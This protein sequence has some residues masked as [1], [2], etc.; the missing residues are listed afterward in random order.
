MLD[1]DSL[2]IF[3]TAAET[4]NFTRTAQRLH[5]S[6]PSVSQH[7]QSLEQH[8]GI[9][10]FE[11]H[12]RRVD[13]SAVGAS[14]LPLVQEMLRAGR[15]VEEAARVL[16]GEVSGLLTLACSTSSGKYIV[17]RLLA[18]YRDLYPQ[19]QTAMRV[20]PRS[21]MLDWLLAGEADVGITSQ[22][23]ECTGV[24]Y[25]RFFE[26][27]ISLIV[28]AGHPWA[29]QVSIQAKDLYGERFIFREATAGTQMA[30]IESLDALGVD[31]E[32]LECGLVLDSSEAIVM[33]VEENM[34]VAFVP[35]VTAERCMTWGHIKAVSVEG[36]TITHWLYLVDNANRSR[37]P[38]ANAFWSYVEELQHLTLTR[39]HAAQTATTERERDAL[40]IALQSLPERPQPSLN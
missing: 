35:T 39:R 30:V 14:L 31:V 10:L 18:R 24:H 33:A 16:N 2:R 29:K 32:H 8:L 5:I 9:E 34:G 19:V 6:Q 37:T 25:R 21:Q 28:P 15:Q 22:R 7:I 13:L 23:V 26:D 40:G 4:E 3:V 11:R 38:A 20:G 12:G 27:K 1:L 17:P 36:M